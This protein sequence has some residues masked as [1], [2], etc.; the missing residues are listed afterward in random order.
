MGEVTMRRRLAVCAVP[1]SLPAFL[2][3]GVAVLA[4]SN[5]YAQPPN[6][7]RGRAMYENHCQLADLGFAVAR[8]ASLFLAGNA[9]AV[10]GDA[11]MQLA[12]GDVEIV[13]PMERPQVLGRLLI[14]RR[15]TQTFPPE[16]RLPPDLFTP[17][18]CP[19]GILAPDRPICLRHN[20]AVFPRGVDEHRSQRLPIFA[21]DVR[22]DQN[23][24]LQLCSR[25]VR[26]G[27]IS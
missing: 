6:A 19:T 1:T 10:R 7:D 3:L 8:R 14:A 16:L 27:I 13:T 18:P 9:G 4:M 2:A 12:I 26:L 20:P 15:D 22:G 21:A 17:H 5:A 24:L 11:A 25:E 23:Q